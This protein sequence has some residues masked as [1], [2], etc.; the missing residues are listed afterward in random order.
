MP[1]KDPLTYSV[2]T[3]GWVVILSMWGG[4]V[5]YHYKM[6]EG[7]VTRFQITEF[8]G[9]LTTSGFSGMI[10]FYLCEYANLPQVLTAALVG[11]AGHM[12]A[13]GIFMIEHALE[14]KFLKT[15]QKEND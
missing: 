4:L 3:Y 13:R 7:V 8:V 12:G 1:D 6:R 9:D 2:L 15:K 5:N 11:V 10:T 14:R